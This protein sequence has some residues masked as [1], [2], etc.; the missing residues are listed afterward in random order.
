[1][2]KKKVKKRKPAFKYNAKSGFGLTIFNYV[3]GG[4]L[5]VSG[6]LVILVSI[7]KNNAYLPVGIGA[8]VMA[9]SFFQWEYC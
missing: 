1:M 2:E 5:L 7:E 6:L 8:I 3:I 4:L 9:F